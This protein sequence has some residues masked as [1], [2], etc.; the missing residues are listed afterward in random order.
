[1]WRSLWAVTPS[2]S[3]RWPRRASSSSAAATTGRMTRSR[4]LSLSRREP[5]E[6]GKTRSS[7]RAVAGG[8][9]VARELVAQRRQDVDEPDAG[10]G[11]GVADRDAAVGEVDVAPAQRR[12]LADPQ[13]GVDQRGDQRAAAGGPRLGLGVELGRRVDHGD[14][15]LGRVEEHGAPP[16]AS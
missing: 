7:A 6:V 15:L 11:L 16:L 12:R 13:A 2:G 10:L 14:D 3:G 9:P 8:V 4:A 1:M 5:L